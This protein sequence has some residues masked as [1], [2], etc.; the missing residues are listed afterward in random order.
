MKLSFSQGLVSRNE[1]KE[2]EIS[3]KYTRSG[4]MFTAKIFKFCKNLNLFEHD[5]RSDQIKRELKEVSYISSSL[6]DFCLWRY[7]L[8]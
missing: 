6:G 1:I 7:P 3:R 8:P 5:I 2:I 4:N